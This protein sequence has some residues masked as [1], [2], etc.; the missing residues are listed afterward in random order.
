MGD[1]AT[2]SLRNIC[3]LSVCFLFPFELTSLQLSVAVISHVYLGEEDHLIAGRSVGA[4][5]ICLCGHSTGSSMH[6]KITSAG[7]HYVQRSTQNK[8][9]EYLNRLLQLMGMAT[10]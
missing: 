8:V 3:V 7:P 5:A 10:Q 2:L 6:P 4:Y 9:R 1:H